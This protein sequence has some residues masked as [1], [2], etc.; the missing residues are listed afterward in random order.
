VSLTH[1]IR[2]SARLQASHVTM[3]VVKLLSRVV[4]SEEDC[5]SNNYTKG[6]SNDAL[7]QFAVIFSGL[8]HDV[9]HLGVPNARLIEEKPEFSAKYDNKSIAE[10]NSIAVAWKLLLN[11]AFA[12]FRTCVAP[13]TKELDIFH[14]TVVLPPTLRTRNS[15]LIAMVDGS[16]LSVPLQVP[17]PMS[18]RSALSWTTRSRPVMSATPCSSGTSTGSG[19]SACLKKCTRL[20]VIPLP[21]VQGRDWVLW[22]LHYSLGQEAG[23]LCWCLQ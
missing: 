21:L 12:A 8:I 23:R 22:F 7:M 14:E 15:R 13:T 19:M 20:S 17:K 11:P 3:S 2:F 10:N 9:D 1:N 5:D 4:A 16:M 6:I 18:S